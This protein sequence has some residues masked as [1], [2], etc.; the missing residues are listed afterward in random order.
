VA[1]KEVEP[2]KSSEGQEPKGKTRRK[3]SGTSDGLV[4]QGIAST[5]RP[6]VIPQFQSKRL[7]RPGSFKAML[8]VL[9]GYFANRL[10]PNSGRRLL[11]LNTQT[12]I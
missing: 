10:R 9:A 8:L 4:Q 1:G 3:A 5:L 2:G 7:P 12:R 6:R 11:C